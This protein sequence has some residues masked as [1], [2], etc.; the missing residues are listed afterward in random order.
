[1]RVVLALA[2]TVSSLAW[3]QLQLQVQ[4]SDELVLGTDSCGE[5]VAVSFEVTSLG[6]NCSDLTFWVTA[7]DCGET[8]GASDVAVGSAVDWTQ[9]RSGSFTFPVTDLPI[10][11]TGDGGVGGCGAAIEDTARVC[12]AFKTASLI[13][14]GTTT[15]VRD[16]SPPSVVYDGQPPATPTLLEVLPLDAAA[17]VNADPN[18]ADAVVVQIELRELG[19]TTWR[20][21]EIYSADLNGARIDGLTNGVT[22]E[23]R[24]TTEDAAGNRSAPSAILEV[25]PQPTL[26]YWTRYQ[27]AGGAE[28]GCNS[29]LGGL[30]AGGMALLLGLAAYAA[31]RWGQGA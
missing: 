10:F 4:E 31:R 27:Q 30:S 17:Q 3:G 25:T 9:T 15:T 8:R 12:G 11:D 6:T 19:Q 13:D 1:M 20:I 2:L 7:G 21:Q 23:V 26:G 29:T 28:V 22:Y 14:C 5:V 18:D 24:V 16:T